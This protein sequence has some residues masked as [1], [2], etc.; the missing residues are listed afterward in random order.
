ME[1]TCASSLKLGSEYAQLKQKLASGWNTWNTRSVL[2]HVLL[3]E[4]IAINLCFK[5][6][7][8]SSYLKEALIGRQGKNDERVHPGLRTYDGRYTELRL[9]WRG[10]SWTVQSTTEGDDLLLLVTPHE[11]GF[12]K[13][14]LVVAE[15]GFLW[16]RPGTLSRNGDEVVASTPQ[17][18]VSLFGT[19]DG[20][21]DPYIPAQGPYLALSVDSPVGFS[22]G[23]QRS[24]ADLT[25]V[26]AARRSERMA[27]DSRHGTL[28]EV[29]NAMQ[30]CVAWDTI[31]DPL[32]DRVISPVSRIWNVEWWGGYVMFCWDSYFAA[33]M[34]AMDNR[35]LAYANAIEIT[36]EGIECG[37]V[38]N[39]VS[40]Q[41]LWSR[42][43]SQPPVGSLMVLMIFQRYQEK[44]FL[45][46]VFE[47][48]LTWNRWWAEHRQVDG[49]LAWG[50]TPFAPIMGN[51]VEKGGVNERFGAALESGLDNAPM[52]DDIPFDTEKHVLPLQDVGLNA[53]YVQDCDALAAIADELGRTAEAA[54][55]R[56]RGDVFR[57]SMQ[58]LWDESTGLFLNRRTD[59]GEFSSRLSPTHFYPLLAG[60]ASKQQADRMIR[61]H[62]F[63]PSEFWGEWILPSC[64]RND[65]AD[66]EQDYWRGRI[67]AP[68][69]FLVYLGL[70]NYDLPEARQALVEKSQA[71][72]LKEW[73]EHGHVHENYCADTG[74]GCNKPNS[75]AFYHWGGLLGLISILEE[76]KGGRAPCTS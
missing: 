49:L 51:P 67:W 13:A 6:Y 65:P 19:K 47:S 42:D 38:P 74:E 33:L 54:E 11:T 73:R 68:M 24:L 23:R 25:A 50:S 48:L 69:N 40:P 57:T 64:A 59:T 45:E 66:P 34:A 76:E 44:W 63:N 1:S 31:Y 43:R 37:F 12:Q 17:R 22:T 4:G 15:I 26:I 39:F 5:H 71:L 8:A 21:T 7:A 56:Q 62:F 20:V 9:T 52:Y 58:R 55:L 3:P 53:L 10:S 30:T 18:S 27:E 16:N 29:H 36:R 46:E 14:P 70:Q 60:I 2:S 75:D 61:E 32:H 41:G 72:L 35:E 28:S